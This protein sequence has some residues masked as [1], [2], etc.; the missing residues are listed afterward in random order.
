M[1]DNK[2]TGSCLCGAIRY[3]IEP[4]KGVFQ[5]CYCSRC[6][7]TS[8]SM[9]AA[10]LIIDQT[11]FHWLEGQGRLGRYVHAE[12]TRFCNAFC[13]DCGSKMPW[14]SRDGKR[15]I[16]PAGTLDEDPG[17]RPVRG[18]FADSAAPWYLDPGSVP[19]FD[20]VPPP[21]DSTD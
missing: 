20:T 11:Q 3:Q 5:Y 19:T 15:M 2:A 14:L 8:G 13:R 10:N 6:R 12:A 1:S 9:G 4:E 16:V 18:I 7:K 21:M 17:V